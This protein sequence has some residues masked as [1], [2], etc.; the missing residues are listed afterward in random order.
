[1]KNQTWILSVALLSTAG[2]VA[3]D[4]DDTALPARQSP[5][6]GA[7]GGGASAND[8]GGQGATAGES[9]QTGS[10]QAGS[11][12]AGATATEPP[13]SN[14]DGQCIFRNDTF[15]DEQLWTDTLRLHEVVQ[16][17]PPT[18]ALA[19]G[20]KVDAE[21]VP[22]EVLA[23]ADL[24]APA[25]TVALLSL[26][27]VVGVRATVIDGQVTSIGISCALC[28]ST[29]DDSVAPGIGARLDGQPNRELD[30]GAI[31]A[32]TPGVGALAKSLGIP[33][34]TAKTALQSWGKGRYDARLN[35]DGESFPVLIPPAYGLADV[36]LETYTGEGPISYWNAYVAITQMGGQGTFVD[37]ERGLDIQADP[38][39]VTPKLAALRKYQFSLTPPTAPPASFDA[40]AAAR[41]DALFHGTAKCATCHTGDSYTDAPTLHDPAETGMETNE[42]RRSKMGQYR[43]TPLRGA[44]SHPPYFHD[45][46]AAT[47]EAVVTHYNTALALGLTAPQ[48]ADLAAY[49]KSL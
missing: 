31:I 30:P 44:F 14:S 13:C 29:V 48:Q 43:T 11:S 12:Q 2:F 34:A 3:C 38:D 49:L 35:Q 33:V 41:G 9:S 4:D 26:N 5:E 10:S 6:A 45:G 7:G 15:G 47:L 23:S 24:A 8:S 42:A 40:A 20:L 1:M 18:A 46:S 22:A 17:L 25:T 19:L 28:H 36:P 37:E 39:L 32:A 16:T 27:A 21:A